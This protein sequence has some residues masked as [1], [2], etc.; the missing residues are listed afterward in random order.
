MSLASLTCEQTTSYS[1]R[2]LRISS[3]GRSAT[4]AVDDDLELVVVLHAHGVG[5]VARVL[6]QLG[7]AHG[8]EEPLGDLLVGGGDREPLAVGG[9]VHAARRRRAGAVA[10]AA[11]DVAGAGVVHDHVADDEHQRLVERD[12]DLVAAAV[13]LAAVER[14]RGAHR[15]GDAG[16]RVGEAER[17]RG[18]RGLGPAVDVGE[19]AAGLGDRA[20]ARLGLVGAEL[21]EAGDARHHDPRVDLRERLV[22]DPPGVDP[23]GPEVLDDHVDLGRPCAGSARAPAGCAG[24]APASA[25]RS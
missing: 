4:Q 8:G 2:T 23:A 16:D 21:A 20:E 24:R 19:A 18:R 6:D 1:S 13:A 15:G 17:R 12:V 9:G 7:P 10:D 25:C 3:R 11:L 14:H 22:A 5:R